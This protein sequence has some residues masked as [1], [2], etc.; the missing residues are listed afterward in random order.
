MVYSSFIQYVYKFDF[1]CNIAINK[2]YVGPDGG[3]SG[4]TRG[5]DSR[6]EE[7][8]RGGGEEDAC[9]GSAADGLD[10]LLHS[11]SF[12]SD[13]STTT[14]DGVPADSGSGNS[15]YEQLDNLGSFISNIRDLQNVQT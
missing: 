8:T 12:D 6:G 5:S 7:D 10:V 13:G 1:H 9:R 11:R 14:S 15:S 3:A 4:N 2:Y